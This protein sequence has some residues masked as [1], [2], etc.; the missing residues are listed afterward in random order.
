MSCLGAGNSSAQEYYPEDYKQ[1]LQAAQLQLAQQFAP[2]FVGN[3]TAAPNTN[4]FGSMGTG[5][6]AFTVIG[7]LSCFGCWNEVASLLQ[8]CPLRQGLRCPIS[9]S[10]YP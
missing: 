3:V 7:F 5:E 4:F 10:L 9:M 1:L 8:G 6:P 2:S